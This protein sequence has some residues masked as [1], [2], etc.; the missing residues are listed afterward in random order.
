MWRKIL[1]LAVLFGGVGSLLSG[2]VKPPDAPPFKPPKDIERPKSPDEPPGAP[3]KTIGTVQSYEKGKSLVL[4]TPDGA[5]SFDLTHADVSG[6][7]D[8]DVGDQVTVIKISRPNGR[9]TL[10]I[11][12]NA[13]PE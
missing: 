13:P 7:T 12:K 5:R 6:D 8:L 10:A 2:Q 11:A 1:L 9:I 4:T 3:E